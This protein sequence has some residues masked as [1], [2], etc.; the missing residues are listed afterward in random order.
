MVQADTEMHQPRDEDS[1]PY[2]ANLDPIQAQ[3]CFNTLMSSTNFFQLIM[4]FVDGPEGVSIPSLKTTGRW[5]ESN[6]DSDSIERRQ[7]VMFFRIT[8][9]VIPGCIFRW[10]TRRVPG[11]YYGEIVF[12]REAFQ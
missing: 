7:R 5:S 2:G 1:T 8:S 11:T 6:S 4:V 12:I 3:S 9:L 10:E